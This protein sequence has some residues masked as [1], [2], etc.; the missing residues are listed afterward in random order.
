[1]T[2]FYSTRQVAK[3]LGIK[4]DTLQ[5]AIWTGRATPPEKSPSG[6]YLWVKADI[7]RISWALLHRSLDKVLEEQAGKVRT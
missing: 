4:P 3:L 6:Q 2:Q 1:M 5:K 7:E